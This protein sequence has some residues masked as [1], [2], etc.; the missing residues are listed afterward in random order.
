VVPSGTPSESPTVSG[1][2]GAPDAMPA[3]TGGATDPGPAAD[4]TP[5]NLVVT[6]ADNDFWKVG[7]WTEASSGSPNVTVNDGQ[8]AQ[9]WD[10][11]GGAFNEL[12]WDVLTTQALQ[13]EAIKLL[14]DAA[15]GANIT[16]G[17]IP[18]GASDYARDRYTLDDTGDDVE[19]QS[20][21]GNRPPADTELTK[22]SLARDEMTLIPYI[23]AAQAV[24]SDMHFW[25]S[26]W[27]P[28]TW[29]KTG[30][31]TDSG[32]TGGGDAKRP[33]Y[34]DGGNMKSD[35]AILE[36]YAQYYKKFVTGYKD[37]GIDIEIVSP[38]N[39]PGYDQNYP[40]CLWDSATYIKFVGQHLGPTMK[41]IG[42]SIML[43][44]MSNAGDN[45]KSD[46]DLATAIAG[47]ATA[48]SFFTV[49]G[50]QWG[51]LAKV[52]E[53]SSLGGLPI[54]ATEHKCG[55]YPWNPSGYPMYNMTQAP[56][57]MA[58]GVES[59]GYIKDAINKGKV[60][61]YSAW[62]MVLDKNGLGNDLSR[63]WRQNALLVSDGGMIKP[64][65][66]YYVFRHVAQYVTPGA[67][68]V[69][70]G[71]DAIGFKN[72]NGSI[73]AIIYNS[74]SANPNYVVSIG[75]KNV[76]FAMPGAGWATVKVTP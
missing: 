13:D 53:G 44:T 65:P 41:D 15:D 21:E 73:V 43:G 20:G 27:T 58:Y 14:F 23:K 47:D 51:V 45:N 68:V 7:E 55:N 48:K 1:T 57:D 38:Q 61:S 31:K 12:G 76:T 36:A 54:W 4:P 62:N 66:Y 18:I 16:W 42:V 19:A 22:F 49:A 69:S 29:M 24:K 52:N 72:P 59:W 46:L 63:D 71:N 3:G 30:Y 17:R 2:G 28:P 35:D 5:P 10:G 25:A 50:A 8:T 9:K 34:F 70:A 74:G 64:T 40:S 26:P 33:S 6:S 32:G 67:T 75:G 60:T 56:N 37:K 39:E 11:F